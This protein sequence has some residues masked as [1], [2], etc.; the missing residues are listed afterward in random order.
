MS[1]FVSE[2]EP[3]PG[4]RRTG[5]DFYIVSIAIADDSPLGIQLAAHYPPDVQVPGHSVQVDW[6]LVLTCHRQYI[7]NLA[8]QQVPRR[9]VKRLL[10]RFLQRIIGVAQDLV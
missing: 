8:A 6:G 3:L 10:V 9:D 5:I 7:C 1:K 2:G 4:P